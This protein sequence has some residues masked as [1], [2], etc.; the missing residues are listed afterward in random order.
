MPESAKAGRGLFTTLRD[1]LRL[2][3][4]PGTVE[5]RVRQISIRSVERPAPERCPNCNGP[6]VALPSADGARLPTGMTR[7][8]T[9]CRECGIEE[10]WNQFA[11]AT[12]R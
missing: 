4:A 5:D 3:G 10:E 1:M 9:F 8:R 6:L 2:P 11:G 12:A 7:S